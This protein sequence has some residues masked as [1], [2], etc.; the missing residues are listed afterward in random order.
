MKNE[1][2]ITETAHSGLGPQYL[3]PFNLFTLILLEIMQQVQAKTKILSPVLEY[4]SQRMF[5]QY[6]M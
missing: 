2:S 6:L 1:T 3:S 5:S 4:T